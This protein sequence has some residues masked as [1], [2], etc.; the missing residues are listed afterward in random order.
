VR[1]GAGILHYR[2][3]PGVQ[4]TIDG[5]L[6]QTRPPDIALVVEHASGDGSAERIRAAYPSVEVMALQDNRGPSAGMNVMVRTLLERGADAI[7]MLPHDVELAPDALE[8]LA[9]RLEEE[10]GLGAVGPLVALQGQRER[11]FSAGGHVRRH[12]WSFAYRDQPPRLDDWTGQP[13]Q[14]ADFLELGGLLVRS[15]AIHAVGK[16]PEHFY[17]W[18]DDVDWTLRMSAAGWGVECVPA[19]VAWQELGGPP[20]Y[21][22]V[23]NTLGVI[24]RNAPRRYLARELLRNVYLLSRDAVRTTSR[25]RAS[26]KPRARG[27]VDYCLGRWGP[28]PPGLD[29]RR[30]PGMGSPPDPQP[31][32]DTRGRL[33]APLGLLEHIAAVAGALPT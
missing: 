11:I 13:P 33:V 5:L 21:L 8:R 4:R 12:N 15:D 31:P 6:Q 30:D 9:A 27:L 18:N 14:R 22:V 23:R 24:G 17:Y 3:W 32:P 26:L 20:W 16:L 7:F 2:F 29:M 19:A 28:P 1:V 10:P 25:P